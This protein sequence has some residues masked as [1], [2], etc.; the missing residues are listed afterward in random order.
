MSYHS[1]LDLGVAIKK[2]ASDMPLEKEFSEVE[3]M[4]SE[5]ESFLAR[6]VSSSLSKKKEYYVSDM[7]ESWKEKFVE[8]FRLC[9]ATD[10][11]L[12]FTDKASNCF[13]EAKFFFSIC[14]V[15]FS[16]E[17]GGLSISCIDLTEEG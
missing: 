14:L 4:F 5:S 16:N 9:K 17:V 2:A 6:A 11:E 3:R 10:G 7:D 15:S 1:Y 13:V 8:S 12:S